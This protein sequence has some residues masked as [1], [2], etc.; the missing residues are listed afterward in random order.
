MLFLMQMAFST[1]E[2]SQTGNLPKPCDRVRSRAYGT[3][4]VVRDVV[5]EREESGRI[6]L[7]CINMQTGN[8]AVLFWHEIDL[9]FSS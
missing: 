9:H 7:N 6:V 3:M 2:V 4:Y 5:D 8:D 1:Y